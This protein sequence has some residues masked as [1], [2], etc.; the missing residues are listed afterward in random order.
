MD[1]IE[2]VPCTDSVEVSQV[3]RVCVLAKKY[4]SMYRV[5]YSGTLTV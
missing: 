3:L 5:I 2:G 1:S 4:R